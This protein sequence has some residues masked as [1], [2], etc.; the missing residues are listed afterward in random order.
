MEMEMEMEVSSTGKLLSVDSFSLW[1]FQSLGSSFE[2]KLYWMAIFDIPIDHFN[3][4]FFHNF[5]GEIKFL[6]SNNL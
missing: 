3:V 5:L 4:H 6:T 1:I 2:G